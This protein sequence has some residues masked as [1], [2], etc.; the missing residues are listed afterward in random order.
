[1]SGAIGARNFSTAILSDAN[2]RFPRGKV[3]INPGVGIDVTPDALV[4]SGPGGRQLLRCGAEKG[5]SSFVLCWGW[6]LQFYFCS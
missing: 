1:M 2:L 4:I 5:E 3:R 6:V